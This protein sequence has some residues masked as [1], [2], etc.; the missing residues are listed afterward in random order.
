MCLLSVCFVCVFTTLSATK[1]ILLFIFY[2]GFFVCSLLNIHKLWIM[3]SISG[4]SRDIA[5]GRLTIL[6]KLNRQVLPN[7]RHES[8]ICM[9]F[10]HYIIIIFPFICIFCPQSSIRV[11][12][13]FKNC[14]IINIWIINAH[15]H[16][17][18]KPMN[19]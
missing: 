5:S 15:W 11:S 19:S 7:Q 9:P 18:W 8:A 13:R 1:F 14:L 12:F 10:R 3:L 16:K 6:F 4:Q 2:G 17:H